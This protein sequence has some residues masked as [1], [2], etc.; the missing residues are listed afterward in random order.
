MTEQGEGLWE[1]SPDGEPA[2]ALGGAGGDADPDGLAGCPQDVLRAGG[3]A[4]AQSY[5]PGYKNEHG[6]QHRETHFLKS[7]D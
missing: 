7:S 3:R 2:W 1:N 5:G 4:S 6:G